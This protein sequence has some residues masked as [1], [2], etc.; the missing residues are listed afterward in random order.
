MLNYLVGSSNSM[1]F[2]FKQ[3]QKQPFRVVFYKRLFWK[4]ATHLQENTHVEVWFQ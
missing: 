2:N 1:G 4:Y 3:V